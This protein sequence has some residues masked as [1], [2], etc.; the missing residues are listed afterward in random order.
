MSRPRVNGPRSLIITI[1]EAPVIGF[2][3]LTRVPNGSFLCCG[4]DGNS[5][6]AHDNL[7]A[8]DQI[9]EYERIAERH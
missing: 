9:S 5:E 7:P 8:F 6:S 2:V 3:T 1:A 4:R